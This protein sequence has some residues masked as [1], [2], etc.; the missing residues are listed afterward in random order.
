MTVHSD[1]KA[2]LRPCT[3]VYLALLLLTAVTWAVGRAGLSGLGVSLAVLGLALFKGHLIGDWFMGL[4]GV[5]GIWRAVIML[6]L[7]LTG[8]LIGVAFMLSSGG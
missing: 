8:G 7:L 5:R 4:R 3:L 1:N 6:W 2:L